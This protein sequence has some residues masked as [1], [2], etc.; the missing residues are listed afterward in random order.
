MVS[1]NEFDF[2]IIGII[3]LSILVSFSRG[4]LRETISLITWVIGIVCSIRFAPLISHWME[5]LITASIVRYSISFSLLFLL[6]FF[7][8]ALIGLLLKRI[9]TLVGLS[10]A[11]RMLGIVFG[12]ARGILAVAVIL[13]FIS[14]TAFERTAWASQSQLSPEFMPLVQWLDGFFPKKRQTI[15]SWNKNDDDIDINLPDKRDE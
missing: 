14:M 7:I 15:T 3:F 1:L 13:V 4:F 11:D 12:A 8:G 6:I 9:V 10:F 2:I 5:P